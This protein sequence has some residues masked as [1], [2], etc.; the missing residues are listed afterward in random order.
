MNWEFATAVGLCW[1]CFVGDHTCHDRERGYCT[2][3]AGFDY[4]WCEVE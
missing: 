2:E 3:V 4:C 1:Q